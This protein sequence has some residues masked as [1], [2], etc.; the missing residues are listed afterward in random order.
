[1]KQ[2]YKTLLA[3]ALLMLTT[4][5]MW[6]QGAATSNLELTFNDDTKKEYAANE[7]KKVHIDKETGT[8]SVTLVNGETDEYVC[9]VKHIGFTG[10]KGKELFPELKSYKALKSYVN[11]EGYPNFMVGYA[12]DVNSLNSQAIHKYNF[13]EVVAG[14]EF[15]YSSCV[16]SNGSMDF[17]TVK[18]FIDIATKG[19]MKVYGHCLAWHSQQQPSYLN[20]LITIKNPQTVEGDVFAYTF[21]D[22]NQLGGWGNSQQRSI[23]TGGQSGKCLKVVNPSAVQSWESQVAADFS[24]E[25][26]PNGE[27]TLH[28]WVKGSK[29]GQLS[30]NL[31]YP[32]SDAGYPSRG[33][34]GSFDVTTS[35]QEVTL[36]A[37]CNGSN[38]TRLLFNI[39]AYA[40]TLYFDEVSLRGKGTEQMSSEK[41]L[42]VLTAAMERWIK[43]MMEACCGRVKAWDVVNEAISGGGNDGS[44]NYTLQHNDGN[45]NHFFWQDHMGDL[46]YVRTAV[47]LA[48]QYGPEDV[49]LFIND[50]NLESDWDDN[51][52]LKSLINWIKKWE[53]DGVTKIDGI[54]TQMHI[55]C[56]TNA[57]TL[58]S[59]KS[60]VT[61]MF[62]LMAATGKLVRVSELDMG[63]TDN[64]GNKILTANLTA[65]QRQ[66]MAEYY[67]FIVDQY[68]TIVPPAQQWGICQ[69]CVGDSPVEPS[70]GWRPGEPVGLWNE[71]KNTRQV[72]FKGFADGL[73]GYQ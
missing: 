19:G 69:W 21:D 25:L 57:S 39:G 20:G 70:W 46:E 60:H 54:G 35:W 40:G 5:T 53:A 50:Y 38:A 52:K 15:K 12:T 28:F 59:R 16:R 27:Y 30:A 26:T 61:N 7:V 72:T 29:A 8:V 71:S 63:M 48:R 22:G 1:M 18:R 44:G 32:S 2:N 73:A 33:D 43:G 3:A 24:P 42:E 6:A 45:A 14:N 47:R 36:K 17:S 55:S 64:S 13:E 23:V 41:K 66:A 10:T 56:S 49:K 34:F 9:Q 4:T 67:K 65:A 11:K 37:T 68:L 31:Q 62:K 51:K 58:A